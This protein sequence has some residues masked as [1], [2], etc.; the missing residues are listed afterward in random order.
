M[1]KKLKIKKSWVKWILV[2][3]ILVIVGLLYIPTLDKKEKIEEPVAPVIV[4]QLE[5]GAQ[6]GDLMKINYVLSFEN[7]TVVDTNNETLAKKYGIGTYTKGTYIF[8]LGQSGKL[9]GQN[10]A[11]KAFDE[12]IKGLEVGDKKTLAIKP[13]EKVIAYK[14]NISNKEQRR[15]TVPA[16]QRFS[17][18]KFNETFSQQP[19]VGKIVSNSK[20]YPWP[21][22]VLNVTENSAYAQ[23]IIK[24]GDEVVIPGTE[25]KSMALDVGEKVIVFVQNPEIG[26]VIKTDYGT[27]IVTNLS[28]GYILFEHKPEL[29]KASK[30]TI[31]AQREG[32]PV[33]D[34]VVWQI[35]EGSF[36]IRRANYLLQEKLKLDVEVLDIT[37]DVKEIKE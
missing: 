2:I 15:A 30:Q 18:A 20:K 31:A 35:D 28:R 9:L 36:I 22:K 33:Y 24:N 19:V 34:F 10:G 5:A 4:P 29:G 32:G 16:L 13:S 3:A 14:I 12:A 23:I 21:Y 1:A 11:V 25:W 17:I 8:I 27:A 6:F 26:Q 37:E 7:G